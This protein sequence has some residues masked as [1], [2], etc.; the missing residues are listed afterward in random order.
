MKHHMERKD[1]QET[2]STR[3]WSEEAILE[4][5]HLVLAILVDAS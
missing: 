4:M 5:D 2:L 1:D 3:H